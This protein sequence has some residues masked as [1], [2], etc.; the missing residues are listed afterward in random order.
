MLR[1]LIVCF[2][3]LV[4]T[5]S[6]QADEGSFW[7]HPSRAGINEPPGPSQ[8]VRVQPYPIRGGNLASLDALEPYA[9]Y[10]HDDVGYFLIDKEKDQIAIFGSSLEA[11]VTIHVGK[12]RRAIRLLLWNAYRWRIDN[13]FH[14][15]IS[16]IRFPTGSDDSR[17][18]NVEGDVAGARLVR[19]KGYN[20]SA[21]F[22]GCLRG[23]YA[24]KSTYATLA[25]G[26]SPA[27]NFGT[28]FAIVGAG[29]R[30]QG[31]VDVHLSLSP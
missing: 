14:T 17:F 18:I 5:G 4:L 29:N 16:E 22:S 21:S 12:S 15:Q 6:A 11:P 31:R 13:P 26:M 7:K 3:A 10:E 28:F 2:F 24:I 27:W 9:C 23:A 30:Q 19:L 20:P 1:F 8:A 25:G